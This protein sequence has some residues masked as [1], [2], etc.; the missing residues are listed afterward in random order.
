MTFEPCAIVALAAADMQQWSPCNLTGRL[1]RFYSVDGG[2]DATER[3]FEPLY[4]RWH[5]VTRWW[6]GVER[7]WQVG[8]HAATA[9]PMLAGGRCCEKTVEWPSS[10]PHGTRCVLVEYYIA[11]R[12]AALCAACRAASH[13]ELRAACHAGADAVAVYTENVRDFHMFCGCG[14]DRACASCDV[15]RRTQFKHDADGTEI[16]DTDGCLGAVGTRTALRVPM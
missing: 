11:E 3:A 16:A 1:L 12:L 13:A 15:Y 14:R 10:L 8:T 2:V 7:S 9:A 6:R 4:T 5:T